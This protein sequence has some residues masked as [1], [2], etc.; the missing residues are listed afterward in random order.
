[1]VYMLCYRGFINYTNLVQHSFLLNSNITLLEVMESLC[2]SKGSDNIIKYTTN[3][4]I[5][6]KLH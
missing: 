4:K 6:K 2:I 5:L 1:M 3:K